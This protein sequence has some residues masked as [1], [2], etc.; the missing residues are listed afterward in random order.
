MTFSLLNQNLVKINDDAKRDMLPLLNQQPNSRGLIAQIAATHA[1]IITRN[2][3]FY[4]PDRMKSGVTSWTDNYA[5]PILLHH[6]EHQDPVGRVISAAYVDTSGAILDQ[7]DGH[8]VKD[9]HGKEIGTITEELLRDFLSDKMPFGQKVDIIRSL[10]KSTILDD[11]LYEG[12]GFIQITGQI[13]NNEAIQK[14]LDGRYVT[15]SVGATTNRAVCSVCRKD[16]TE[17]GPCEHRPGAIYDGS[18]AFIIA[19]DLIYEEYSFVNVPADR[20][21]RVLELNYNGIKNS[22]EIAN[23]YTGRMYEVQLEFPQY[24]SLQEASEM[25]KV[26]DKV[27]TTQDEVVPPAETAPSTTVVQP[28]AEP[29]A[30]ETLDTLLDHVL[31]GQNL[32]DEEE[33]KL[34]DAMWAEVEAAV[35]DGELKLTDEVLKD[36]KLSTAKRKKLAKSTFCGPDKS[37]PVPDCAHVTAARRLIGRYKGSGNKESILACV[38]RKAKS[39]GCP[40]MDGKKMMSDAVTETLPENTQQQNV[41]QQDNM[42]AGHLLRQALAMI[43]TDSGEEMYMSSPGAEKEQPL[44]TDEETTTLRTLMKRM[45][46]LVGKDA[47]IRAAVSEGLSIDPEEEKALLDE[48]AHKEED[49]GALREQLAVAQVELG[50][51]VKDGAVLQDSLVKEKVKTR[52]AKEL[53]VCLLSQLRDSKVEKPDLVPLSDENLDL[54]VTRLTEVVDITKIVD[55]LGDGMSRNPTGVIE[56]PTQVRDQKDNQESKVSADSLA[57]IEENYYRILFTKGEKTAEA[58]KARMIREGY[59]P[60]ENN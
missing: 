43:E 32:S 52:Q 56:D 53:Y 47:F 60:K 17:E 36:A 11:K 3:G 42:H 50:N 10:F 13:T 59:L 40:G 49:L 51:L 16:W 14:L 54:E 18:K 46:G 25:T 21:S 34:Y 7:Y 55:K 48:V 41:A 38:S 6:Q 20:H 26:K 35:K 27:T 33:D 37:F 28:P 44:L 5:K 45:A 57:K 4:L 31:A 19:G 2:H 12:M 8:T 29:T 39:M 1:G 15:G 30:E 22:I 24:D 23:E 58:Y 9:S